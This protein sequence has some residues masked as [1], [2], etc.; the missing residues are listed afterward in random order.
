MDDKTRDSEL[1]KFNIAF[2]DSFREEER[3]EKREFTPE[4]ESDFNEEDTGEYDVV[5]SL[6]NEF[7]EYDDFDTLLDE[8]EQKHSKIEP[9]QTQDLTVA[10]EPDQAPTKPIIE[11]KIDYFYELYHPENLISIQE[12]G[13]Q[14]AQL[15]KSLKKIQYLLAKIHYYQSKIR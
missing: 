4:D 14:I 7:S 12:K 5:E 1:E 10:A 3:V 9:D 6:L 8:A 15:R 13:N 11:P 2:L